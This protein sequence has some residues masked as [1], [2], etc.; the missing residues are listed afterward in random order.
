MPARL[1][2]TIIHS[3]DRFAS[4]RFLTDLLGA[5]GPG[6]LG[7]FATVPLANGV[8]VDYADEIVKPDRIVMQHLAFLV[9]EEEFDQIWERIKARGLPYWADPGHRDPQRINHRHHGRGVYVDDPDGHAIEFLT[10]SYE[11]E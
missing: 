5:P 10:H 2:H 7:P 3:T 1:D 8:T 9:S 4:A 6:A 11:A